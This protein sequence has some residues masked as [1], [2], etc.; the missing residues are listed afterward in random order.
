[1]KVL[2]RE[3]LKQDRLPGRIIQKVVGNDSASISS[4]MTVSF[5]K[6][7]AES[8]PMEP[9]QH[10]EETVY[11]IDAINGWVRKGPSKDCLNEKVML[12]KDTVLH[13][14]ELE[15][16]VFEYGEDGFVDALCIYGQVDNIRPE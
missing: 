1:M 10:A 9:H 15:W 6:Y 5:A 7:S 8:G 13:F 11:I 4:K 14:E 2:R 16:H 12:S 3:N